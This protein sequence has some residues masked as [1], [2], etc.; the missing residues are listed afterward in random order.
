MCHAGWEC[1]N[2][3]IPSWAAE[4]NAL[5][6]LCLS[7]LYIVNPGVNRD[8]I[9]INYYVLINEMQFTVSCRLGMCQLAH[10]Q[11]GC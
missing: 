10:T 9:L 3:H 2:W 6:A 1:A 8:S 7:A 11:L 5:D 4:H